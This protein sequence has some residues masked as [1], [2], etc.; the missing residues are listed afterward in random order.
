LQS[1]II[2]G[3][4]LG[5]PGEIRNQI[6]AY[7]IYPELDAITIVNCTKPEHL[8]ASVLHLPLFRAS[9]QIRAEALSY[10]CATFGIKILGLETAN[11]FFSCAG[12][13]ISEIKTLVLVQPVMGISESNESWERV[14]KFF[15]FLG[16]M[17]ELEAFRLDGVGK[18]HPIG[19]NADY[20]EFVRR[21]IGLGERKVE[22]RVG[23][24]KRG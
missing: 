12:T 7:V 21:V 16:Q 3:T 6:Y 14:E 10:L 20:E 5:L 18:M 2:R 19:M 23:Y 15:A 11:V 24:W 22:V 13:A 4:F 1:Q 9:H 8:A 17:R